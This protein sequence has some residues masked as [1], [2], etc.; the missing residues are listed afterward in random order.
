MKGRGLDLIPEYDEYDDE[1]DDTYD[2]HNVGATDQ[3]S[4]DEM[5]AVKRYYMYN[6]YYVCM[7]MYVW[8]YTCMYICNMYVLYVWLRHVIVHIL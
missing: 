1:Y 6:L 3:D 8:L 5:T 4:A 2:S 7:Y